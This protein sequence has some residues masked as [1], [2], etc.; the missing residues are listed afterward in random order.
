[1]DLFHITQECAR[2]GQ[3]VNIESSLNELRMPFF[4]H[5]MLDA[6]IPFFKP[7]NG[8]AAGLCLPMVDN[9]N[10]L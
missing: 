1:M 9:R 7:G 10:S 6:A 5:A 2:K 8:G 3:T 4:S